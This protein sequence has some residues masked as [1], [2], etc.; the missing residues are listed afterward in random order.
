MTYHPPANLLELAA[1]LPDE[2]MFRRTVIECFAAS[3][4]VA[5]VFPQVTLDQCFYEVETE[6]CLPD[7]IDP[8]RHYNQKPGQATYGTFDKVIEDMKLAQ[9][10]M[11]D[12]DW[13]ILDCPGEPEKRAR[14]FTLALKVWGQMW[15]DNF[16]WG[17]HAQKACPQGIMERVGPAKS[18]FAKG[19]YS[20]RH[21]ANNIDASTGL[22]VAGGLPLSMT[23]IRHALDNTNLSGGTAYWLMNRRL[24]SQIRAQR[25]DPNLDFD[26]TG[27]SIEDGKKDEILFCGL[28]ILTGYE[29]TDNK[30]FLP[31]TEEPLGGNGASMVP[32]TSSIYLIVM[33]EDAAR[34]VR[35][36]PPEVIT[37]G[38]QV[39]QCHVWEKMS[40]ADRY[41]FV[42][43]KYSLMRISGI[44]CEPIT[45]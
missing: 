30:E 20:D 2:Q 12:V 35:I 9:W 41:G 16:I 21:F 7:I 40:Y 4:D 28:P 8:W 33:G 45:K 13:A 43:P 19:L 1:G 32:E 26:T 38:R 6:S 37:S 27:R 5:M 36:K 23:V 34:Q 44:R 3:S 22:P 31:F 11:P 25:N 17:K 18:P 14:Q 42:F 10:F 15:L 29:F 39:D 24:K